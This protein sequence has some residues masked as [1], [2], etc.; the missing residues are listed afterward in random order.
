MKKKYDGLSKY[1][2]MIIFVFYSTIHYLPKIDEKTILFDRIHILREI[3]CLH[4]QIYY[5][6]TSLRSS[7]KPL[8]LSQKVTNTPFA[9]YD[10]I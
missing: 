3:F 8:N 5:L 9:P 10:T 6:A 7:V 1:F 2:S 4:E